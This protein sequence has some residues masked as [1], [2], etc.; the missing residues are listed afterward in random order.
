MMVD[1]FW[2]WWVVDGIF[3]VMMGDGVYLLGGGSW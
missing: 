1:L 3:W 2:W